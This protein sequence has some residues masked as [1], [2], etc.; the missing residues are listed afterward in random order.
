MKSLDSELE[1][2]SG[3]L[4]RLD[5]VVVRHGEWVCVRLPLVSSVRIHHTADGQFRFVPQIGPFRRSVGLFLTS[6]V[7]AAAVIA[8]AIAYGDAPLTLILAFLGAIA[9]VHDTCR[10]VLTEGCVTRLQQIIESRSRTRSSFITGP[11]S[12]LADSA[13]YTFIDQRTVDQMPVSR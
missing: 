7:S 5:Y 9:L 8:S 6:G 13:Q 12:V 3:E 1:A 4:E 2:L 11:R 10:F